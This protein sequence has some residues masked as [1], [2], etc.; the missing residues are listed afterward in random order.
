MHQPPIRRRALLALAGASALPALAGPADEWPNKP[1]KVIV[2]LPPGSGADTIARFLAPRLQQRF[3]Q[4][5]VVENRT[6]ANSFIAAQFVA[7]AP[8]DGYTLFWASNSP[9]TTNLVT[10]KQLPYD[11]FADFTPLAVAARFPMVFVVPAASPL[12]SMADLTAH[13]REGGGKVPFGSGTATYR[14]AIEQY[15]LQAGVA[16]THVPYK[17]TSA[18]VM[19]LAAGDVAYSLAEI[20]AVA[21]LIKGGRLRALAVT[22]RQRLRD[23]PEVPTMA[24]AGI[25][26]HEVH[27]WVGG[28][29]PARTGPAIVAKVAKAALDIVRSPEGTAY[30]DSLGGIPA[31]MGPK[32][33]G[34]FQESEVAQL[35]AVAARVGMEQE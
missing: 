17:G 12:R 22:S 10:F 34:A 16:G 25:P 6:G 33:L 23:L 7:R 1:V 5:F 29:F 13:L 32:E 24:E 27:A 9:M 28:F 35:R 30:I 4:P 18:A 21:P 26:G 14:L 2:S 11:P 19:G 15:H 20:S 8:A 3:G 31:P